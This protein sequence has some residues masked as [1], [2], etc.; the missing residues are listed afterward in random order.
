MKKLLVFVLLFVISCVMAGLY[1]FLHDQISWTLSPEYFT[2]LK[3]QQFFI[4]ELFHNRLGAGIVG[5]LATWWM[6]L[7]IGIVLIPVGLVIPGWKN[8]LTGMIKVL[9]IVALTAL[10]IGTGALIYGLLNYR[11]DTMPRFSTPVGVNDPVRFSV[12][13]TM[14]NFSYLGGIVG[15]VTGIVAIFFER[16]RFLH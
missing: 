8:Y 5:I 12:V 4:P 10:L 1:G 6:G 14:H 9:G 13:G 3:F 2:Q 16:K 15:I 11:I 7:V